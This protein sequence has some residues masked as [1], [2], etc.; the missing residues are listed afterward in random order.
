MSIDAVVVAYRNEAEIGRCVDAASALGGRVIVVDHGDGE[1]AAVAQRHGALTILNPSNP[2]F[3]AGQNLGVGET[4]TPYVLLCNPDAVPNSAV[5]AAAARWL[6]E[7]PGVAAIQGVIVNTETGRP[8]RSAGAELGPIHLFGR[9]LGARRLGRF[10]A[11]RRFALRSRVLQDHVDR[12]PARPTDV[13]SLA[14]TSLVIRRS[15][16]DAVGGFDERHFLYGEDLDLCHRLR[17]AGWKLVALPEVWAT[18]ISGGSAPSSLSR[19][20]TWW[21]GTMT[22]AARWWNTDQWRL[23]VAAAVVR[24]AGLIAQHPKQ[25]AAIWRAV[26][27]TP[28]ATR[29]R[30]HKIGG[31]SSAEH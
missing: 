11:A 23:G 19:E 31:L 7:H 30:R 14:A 12:A 22:F 29:T 13:E 2:G 26:V 21:E 10:A 16:F 25:S 5:I 3:G 8:E 28:L 15:A 6:D 17:A 24:A 20:L 18:H 27:R 4:T 9:A 1:S